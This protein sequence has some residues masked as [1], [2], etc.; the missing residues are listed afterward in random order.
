MVSGPGIQVTDVSLS[1]S[2][3]VF[4]LLCTVSVFLSSSLRLSLQHVFTH[5]SPSEQLCVMK[6]EAEE[7][8]HIA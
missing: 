2:F 8:E 6:V 5:P 4:L 3:A 1:F 7:Q